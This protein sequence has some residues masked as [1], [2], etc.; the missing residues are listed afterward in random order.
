M[1]ILIQPSDRQIEGPAG[2]EAVLLRLLEIVQGRTPPGLQPDQALSL[3]IACGLALGHLGD[4][5]ILAGESRT[6][7]GVR[8]IQPQW[9][10]V[11]RAGPFPMGSDRGEEGAY[12]QEKDEYEYCSDRPTCR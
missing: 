12:D 1:E 2:A 5:R 10:Q 11:V 9:S 7:D 3:R 4:P 6:P 8:F